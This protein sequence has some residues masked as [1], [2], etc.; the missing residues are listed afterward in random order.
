MTL[1]LRGRAAVA[2][3]S[4]FA[5]CSLGGSIVGNP[6]VYAINGGDAAEGPVGS[7]FL[8][9]GVHFGSSQGGGVVLF[10][11]SVAGVNLT[12]PVLSWGDLAI[13]GTI[14]N[15]AASGPVVVQ[16][17]GGVS[18]TVQFEVTNPAFTPQSISWTAGAALPVGLSGDAA[19][20]AEMITPTGV[21]GITRTLYAVG[22]AAGNDAPGNTVY[23]A[24][25][26]TSGGIAAWTATLSLPESVAFESAVVASV[27]NS[28]AVN[29]PGY[30]LVLGGATD[31][32]G[33]STANIYRG[34]L[35]T[36]GSVARWDLD[37][38]LPAALHSFG[39]VI[40]MGQ[41]YVVGGAGSTNAPTGKVY[42][43]NI[44][45]DGTLGP[46][47]CAGMACW[48]TEPFSLPFGRSHFALAVENGYA[49]GYFYVVGGDSGTVTPNDSVVS[50]SAL[51]DVLY[52]QVD[53]VSRDIIAPGWV[54]TT[55]LPAARTSA[56]AMAAGQPGSLLVTAG[57]FTG[58]PTGE[59][60]YATITAGNGSLGAISAA[61]NTINATCHCILF[62]HASTQYVD[63]S[64][65]VHLLVVG[66]DDMTSPGTKQTGT[67]TY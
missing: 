61:A 23:Y 30:L 64:G 32:T 66:G 50:S 5:A 45:T 17:D 36:N 52:A 55:P 27:L 7:T 38:A 47:G 15:G 43:T 63:N 12:A 35:N 4:L 13:V 40:F 19:A 14:P 1:P 48:V 42:R 67:F 6:F 11:S 56:T 59:E 9:Q 37:G 51:T 57:L 28:A 29:A 8:I 21:N 46:Q 39:A 49:H 58:A 3:A 18:S 25:V 2:L 44:Q 65:V 24:N 34:T 16:T 10:Q 22:G 41:L 54:P 53:L 20:S 33:Q 60:S 26:P 62:N 31:H